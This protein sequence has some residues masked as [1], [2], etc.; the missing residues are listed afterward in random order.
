MDGL[1][2]VQTYRQTSPQNRPSASPH[3]A[4]MSNSPGNIVQRMMQGM[5]MENKR[6]MPKE[7]AP[8]VRFSAQA[9]PCQQPTTDTLPRVLVDIGGVRWVVSACE[10]LSSQGRMASALAS[11]SWLW[12]H[13][14]R[15][16]VVG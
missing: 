1:C 7:H 13:G 12:E 2:R 4:T 9:H 10:L 3:A 16:V 8:E 6:S 5:G 15:P 14:G 11:R